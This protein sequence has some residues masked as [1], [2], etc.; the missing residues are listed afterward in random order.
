MIKDVPTYDCHNTWEYD[1]FTL[2]FHPSTK[3]CFRVG[4]DDDDTE[5][6][7][8]GGDAIRTVSTSPQRSQYDC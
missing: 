1:I 8:V 5:L 2:R 4:V 3:L 6:K 7:H